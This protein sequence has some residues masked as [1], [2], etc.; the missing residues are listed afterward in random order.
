M[1]LENRLN[2]LVHPETF[3]A[4]KSSSRPFRR[5]NNEKNNTFFAYFQIC[6]RYVSEEWFNQLN[7]LLLKIQSQIQQEPRLTIRLS[8]GLV[9]MPSILVQFSSDFLPTSLLL[10]T[11]LDVYRMLLPDPNYFSF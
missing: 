2:F 11:G 7:L 10:L 9:G 8:V 5:Q 1:I 4:I 6:L 3:S